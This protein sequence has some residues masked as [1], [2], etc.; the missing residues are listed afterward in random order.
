MPKLKLQAIR[1]AFHVQY[2]YICMYV[3]MH[4]CTYAYMYI[5][6]YIH[7]IMHIHI[8]HAFIYNSGENTHNQI[9]PDMV[10]EFLEL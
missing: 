1:D 8:Q 5:C 10:R 7:N 3:H 2:M 6:I 4:A 9:V